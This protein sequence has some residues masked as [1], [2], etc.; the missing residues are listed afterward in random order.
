MRAEDLRR[1]QAALEAARERISNEDWQG[2][3]PCA[4]RRTGRCDCR[5]EHEDM[6]NQLDEA[7]A[8]LSNYKHPGA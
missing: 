3:C 8:L 6:L 7:I 4:Y 1:V 5:D 2:E